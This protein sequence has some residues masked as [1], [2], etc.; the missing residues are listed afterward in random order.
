MSLVTTSQ[1]AAALLTS[2]LLLPL[3]HLGKLEREESEESGVVSE[4]LLEGLASKWEGGGQGGQREGGGLQQRD[5]G[6]VNWT[7]TLVGRYYL[8]GY[9]SFGHVDLVDPFC[10]REINRIYPSQAVQFSSLLEEIFGHFSSA[11]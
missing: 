5:D 11:R 8:A 9:Y 7:G 10:N 4:E 1:A 6:G 3:Q 2:P